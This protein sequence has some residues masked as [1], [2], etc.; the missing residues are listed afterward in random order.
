MGRLEKVEKI[1]IIIGVSV[2]VVT[3]IY[4]I[5]EV[6]IFRD[7]VNV[8]RDEVSAIREST[9][10]TL[11]IFNEST[12]P[13]KQSPYLVD[14]K[15]E[16][17]F[18][19]NKIKKGEL[20]YDVYIPLDVYISDIHGQYR[21]YVLKINKI[22]LTSD[23]Q[24]EDSPNAIDESKT[25]SL[26]IKPEQVTN[27]LIL[28]KLENLKF[29]TIK[30]GP[31]CKIEIE[32]EY[33]DYSTNQKNRKRLN[34]GEI[35]FFN[36]SHTDQKIGIGYRNIFGDYSN[37]YPTEKLNCYFKCNDLIYEKLNTTTKE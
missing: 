37:R 31:H 9:N 32:F 13:I 6:N 30:S 25:K 28:V 1:A 22:H 8:L 15:I 34:V 3:L 27:E 17:F 26:F 7:E 24:L 12:K 23:L 21:Y 36:Y 14:C 29:D 35:S 18:Y 2:A 11:Y 10:A 4:F 16:K 19:S 5:S 33:L 20:Y